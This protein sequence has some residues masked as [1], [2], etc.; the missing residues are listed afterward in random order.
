MKPDFTIGPH[1]P[2]PCGGG[3]PGNDL[4]LCQVTSQ[5]PPGPLTIWP[6]VAAEYALANWPDGQF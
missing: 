4:I 6:I 3:L 2:R 1:D 5:T